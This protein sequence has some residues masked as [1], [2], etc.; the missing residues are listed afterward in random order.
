VSNGQVKVLPTITKGANMTWTIGHKGQFGIYN[1]STIYDE[2]GE[3]IITVLGIPSNIK[4]EDL[5]ESDAAKL[6]IA[7]QIVNASARIA[8][9]EQQVT[10]YRNDQVITTEALK[11]NAAE[12]AALKR[13]L[14]TCKHAHVN[15][16]SR[17]FAAETRE[18]PADY[19]Q[20]AQCQDCGKWLAIEDIPE[21]SEVSE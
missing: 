10:G 13:E 19:E 16:H 9:L 14:N 3:A 5:D 11:A 20:S 17:L 7:N 4:L 18:E 1:P 12:I 8:E 15:I 6:A 2:N 21:D